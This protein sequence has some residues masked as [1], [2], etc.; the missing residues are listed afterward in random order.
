MIGVRMGVDGEVVAPVQ[1][2][3]TE[4]GEGG[5]LGVGDGE[6]LELAQVTH[7]VVVQ[8]GHVIHEVRARDGQ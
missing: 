3:Q 2:G 7:G 8:P 5:K 6:V 4:A 1:P